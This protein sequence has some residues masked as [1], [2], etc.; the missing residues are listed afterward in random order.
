MLSLIERLLTI[1]MIGDI[2]KKRYFTAA[3]VMT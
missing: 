1:V 2:D 3:I